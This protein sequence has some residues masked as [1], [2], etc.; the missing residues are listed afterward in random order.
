MGIWSQWQRKVTLSLPPSKVRPLEGSC[1]WDEGGGGVCYSRLAPKTSEKHVPRP[2]FALELRNDDV[3]GTGARSPSLHLEDSHPTGNIPFGHFRSKTQNFN[4][5]ENRNK[6]WPAAQ[7]TGAASCA[8]K[9][10]G[11]E[12]RSGR[13][14]RFRGP[15][16][17]RVCAGGNRSM[18]LKSKFLSSPHPS[19]LS[20]IS[21]QVLS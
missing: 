17:V 2:P 4:Y 15:S 13:I 5:I 10:F 1:Q 21:K 3:T 20:K 11:F 18:F 7:F 9:V 19:S 16:P 14:P 12:A 8:L 6:P